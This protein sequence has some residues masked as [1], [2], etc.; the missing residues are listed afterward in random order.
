MII[1]DRSIGT[2]EALTVINEDDG[3]SKAKN[4]SSVAE[5]TAAKA[6]EETQTSVEEV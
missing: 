2:K 3:D 5:T 4:S 1:R 6:T